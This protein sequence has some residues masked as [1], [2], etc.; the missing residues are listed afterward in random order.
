MR[1]RREGETVS[2]EERRER[3]SERSETERAE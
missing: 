3:Q 2:V 1:V